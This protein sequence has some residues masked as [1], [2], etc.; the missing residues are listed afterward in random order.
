M[1]AGSMVVLGIIIVAA[2]LA[3]G[4]AVKH[5]T[6]QGG[7]CGG[8]STAH[9]RTKRVHVADKNPENYPYQT[10]LKIRGMTCD[11]CRKNVENALDS[12][13]G[14]WATVDLQKREALVRSKRPI[15]ESALEQ[16]VARAGYGV[17]HA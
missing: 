17:I 16:A 8:G 6:G 2:V 12:V 11:H 15:D 3:V 14:T 9:P 7:C 4:P 13:D 10:T 1:S 5:F